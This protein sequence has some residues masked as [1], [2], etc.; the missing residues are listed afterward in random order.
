MNEDKGEINAIARSQKRSV[1][2]IRAYN[3]LD[4][5]APILAEYLKAKEKPIVILTTD[6]DFETDYRV[7]YLRSLGE[8]EVVMD[9]DDEF[10][11]VTRKQG[12]IGRIAKRLYAIKR[13]RNGTFAKIWRRFFFDCSKEMAYLSSLNVGI[14]VFE[15]STPFARG[16]TIEKYFVAAKSIGITTAAIPHGCNIFLNNDSTIGYRKL[17]SR[18]E[19]ADQSETQF[20][21]YYVFQNPIRR[22]GWIKWGFNPA[23]TFA[24]GSTRFYPAWAEINR[25]ICPAFDPPDLDESRFK[26][27]FMQFQKDYNLDN[28]GVMSL[29]LEL[30]QMDG[31]ALA[32]KDATREGKAFYDKGKEAGNLGSSLVGWFGNEVHSP[33]L[34][35]WADCVIVIGGSIGIEAML[36]DTD[37]VYPTY[38]N[39]NETMYE[40]FDSAHCVESEEALM[41]CLL[42]LRNGLGQDKTK[43]IERLFSEIIYAGQ[44]EFDVPRFY[45][46]KLSSCRVHS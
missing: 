36:Q 23:K 27:V 46:E 37:V 6:L 24:W 34:I 16:E 38:L 29:L 7:S 15:W 4:H 19:F 39:Y 41:A 8:L 10:L 40:G 21:D 5:F 32:V 3:D 30:S 1:F 14:C 44:E 45:Y 13:N 9:I 28:E 35:G 25:T 11:R 43:G 42:D 18:G 31:I 26:V 33:S 17:H 22:E 20:F 2:F 12:F